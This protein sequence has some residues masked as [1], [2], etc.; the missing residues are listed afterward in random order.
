[1]F[2]ADLCYIFIYIIKWFLKFLA[3]FRSHTKYENNL[4][5]M[6]NV[7]QIWQKSLL[8]YYRISIFEKEISKSNM[9]IWNNLVNIGHCMS[10]KQNTGNM[11]CIQVH[12]NKC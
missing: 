12:V 3:C 5:C 8:H 10:M 1:M 2:M 6:P 9:T 4:N 11:Q 7:E